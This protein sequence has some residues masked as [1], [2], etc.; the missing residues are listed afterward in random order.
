MLKF[1]VKE[2]VQYQ[3][4]ENILL[5]MTTICMVTIFPTV[6]IRIGR[7]NRDTVYKILPIKQDK[8]EKLYVEKWQAPQ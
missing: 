6:Q 2:G 4:H 1:L 5:Q 7:G 3:Y 8:A